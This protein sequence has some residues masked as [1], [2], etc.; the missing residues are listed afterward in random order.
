MGSRSSRD[1][2]AEKIPRPDPAKIGSRPGSDPAVLQN[3][4][5]TLQTPRGA[6]E[7]HPCIEPG[8]KAGIVDRQGSA[9][10][11]R[12]EGEGVTTSG[13]LL[14]I[15]LAIAGLMVWKMARSWRARTSERHWLPRELQDAQL[16]FAE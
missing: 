5:R 10:D 16:A 7:A 12:A 2:P 4:A 6:Q 1:G 8:I 15:L 11:S 14:L 13:F 9:G 3:G